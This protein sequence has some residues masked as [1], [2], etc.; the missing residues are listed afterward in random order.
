MI[1]NVPGSFVVTADGDQR[2]AE[3][4]RRKLLLE[5]AGGPVPGDTL[6]SVQVP[7]P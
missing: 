1:G 5:V 4:V 7:L 6:A 2:F 3:A